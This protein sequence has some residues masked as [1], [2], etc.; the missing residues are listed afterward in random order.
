M[1]PAEVRYFRYAVKAFAVFGV[2]AAAALVN[3]GRFVA[4]P[5]TP[6]AAYADFALVPSGDPGARTEHALHLWRERRVGAL[7]I[8]GAGYGGDS[9]ERLAAQARS[10]EPDVPLVVETEARSTAD[11]VANSCRLAGVR[12]AIVTDRAHAARVYLAA[13][14][15]CPSWSACTAPTPEPV[16]FRM[17]LRETFRLLGYQLTGR[18]SWATRP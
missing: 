11:N 18:A 13:T 10:L 6:C 5:P 4:D 9:A 14:K 3:A 2:L 8:S 7:V 12:V 15:L 16:T 1:R 17:Q